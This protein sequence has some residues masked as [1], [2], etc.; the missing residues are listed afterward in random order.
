MVSTRSQENVNL[1]YFTNWWCHSYGE[2]YNVLNMF[3]IIALA[4]VITNVY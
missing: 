1:N 3:V 4:D 2:T